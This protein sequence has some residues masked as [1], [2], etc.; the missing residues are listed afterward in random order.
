TTSSSSRV[1]P[2]IPFR[3]SVGAMKET[4]PPAPTQTTRALDSASCSNPGM[5]DW[6]SSAPGTGL[7]TSSIDASLVDIGELI[8]A[9]GII[10]DSF[11]V[12]FDFKVLVEAYKTNE[13]VP[14][15]DRHYRQMTSGFQTLLEALVS[16]RGMCGVRAVARMTVEVG[17]ELVA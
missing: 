5:S 17:Q 9:G 15:E 16:S 1:S 4:I 14:A 10:G 12:D 8:D 6:R 13:A 2:P 3:T 11:S 7:P